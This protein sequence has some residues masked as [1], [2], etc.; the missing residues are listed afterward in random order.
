M[1]K[2]GPC[3]NPSPPLFSSHQFSLDPTV[4]YTYFSTI[5]GGAF[6]ALTVYVS[7]QALV[8]RYLSLPTKRQAKVALYL[9]GPLLILIVG[10]CAFIGL[11]IFKK[12]EDCDPLSTKEFKSSDE[13]MAAMIPTTLGFAPGLPG[14][15]VACI[16]SASISTLSSGVNSLAAIC[17][18]GRQRSEQSNY[19]LNVF[20]LFAMFFDFFS[21]HQGKS[22]TTCLFLVGPSVASL[23]F[24]DFPVSSFVA[25]P[26]FHETVTQLLFNAYTLRRCNSSNFANPRNDFRLVDDRFGISG[27]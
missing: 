22:R 3:N 20:V 15:M 27:R 12:Y 9:N 23:H 17:I 1:T 19:C 21:S 7:N 16:F 10:I 25:H 18:E 5:I 13:M 4:E 11:V 8:Q 24:Y 14:L 26:R 2:L 6:T